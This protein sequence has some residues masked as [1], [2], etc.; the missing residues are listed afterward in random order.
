MQCWTTQPEIVQFAHKYRKKWALCLLKLVEIK[1]AEV[2]VEQQP[3]QSVT[4]KVKI[5]KKKEDLEEISAAA[6]VQGYVANFGS[7]PN[8]EEKDMKLQTSLELGYTFIKQSVIALLQ[9]LQITLGLVALS[10]TVP[11]R[12][13]ARLEYWLEQAQVSNQYSLSHINEDIS[14]MV[15]N[16]IT[17]MLWI[18]QRKNSS[19]DTEQTQR[20]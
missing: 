5:K 18:V 11:L 17:S 20:K 14:R 15:R 3:Q 10:L 13:L 1:A 2:R 19:I 12:L 9:L 4:M 6:G 8:K 7:R 16:G